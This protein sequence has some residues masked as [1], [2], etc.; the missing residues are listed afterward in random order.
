[1]SNANDCGAAQ[2]HGAVCWNELNVH[3]VERAKKFYSQTLGWSFEG[4]PMDGATYWIISSQG[5]RVGGMFEM[6]G[7]ELASVPEHWLT[8][9]GV[10]DVDARL[11]KAKA[12]GATICK[13]AFEIPGV[14]RMAVL[15][16]PGGA[17]VAWM[18]SKTPP[19]A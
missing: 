14:G 1:M 16:Q 3:D 19:S 12:A 17:F 15:Q 9:I 4:M 5:A 7:P 2:K 10:D 13:D 8:Y 11:E 18:T 6:K